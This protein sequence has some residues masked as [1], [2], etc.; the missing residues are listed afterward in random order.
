VKEKSPEV[1]RKVLAGE[2]S[3]EEARKEAGLKGARAHAPG[4]KP[5]AP[6]AAVGGSGRARLGVEHRPDSPIDKANGDLSAPEE[7][8]VNGGQSQRKEPPESPGE[9]TPARPDAEETAGPAAGGPEVQGQQSS[10]PAP[11]AA[12]EVERSAGENGSDGSPGLP[13][14]FEGVEGLGVDID[15]R[16][17]LF[18]QALEGLAPRLTQQQR[19]ALLGILDSIGCRVD[20]ATGELESP[21]SPATPTPPADPEPA[22]ETGEPGDGAGEAPTNPGADPDDVVVTGGEEDGDEG[23]RRGG[24]GSVEAPTTKRM[25]RKRRA[26]DQGAR[27]SPRGSARTAGERAQLP[28][29]DPEAED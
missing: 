18:L 6:T 12:S 16:M 17:D 8:D 29:E 3:F 26:V 10:P 4:R 5:R 25:T 19:D 15:G 2:L 11:A 9:Q 24:R 20:L 28:E 21:S 1:F 22:E 13:R 14:T 7:R 23:R 27:R